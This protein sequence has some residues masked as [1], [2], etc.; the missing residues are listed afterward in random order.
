MNEIFEN[1]QEDAA[2]GPLKQDLMEGVESDEWD[3]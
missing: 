3:D 1:A 2:D